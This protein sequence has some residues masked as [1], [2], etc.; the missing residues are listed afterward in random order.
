MAV[1]LGCLK[2]NLEQGTRCNWSSDSTIAT[3]A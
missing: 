2:Y 1:F 3:T